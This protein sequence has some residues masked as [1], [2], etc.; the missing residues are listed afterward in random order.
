MATFTAAAIQSAFHNIAVDL[1]VSIQGASYQTSLVICVLGGAPIFWRPLSGRFGRR[2]I[3]LLSLI[4]SLIGNIGCAKAPTYGTMGLCRA[5]TA[6]FISPAAAIGSAVVQETF[7][8]NQRARYMGVWTMFVTL[9]VPVAPFI[10][11]FVAQRVSYRWIYW[12]LAMV[13]SL[14]FSLSNISMTI[15]NKLKQINGVQFI[16]YFFFGPES[17]YVR[18]SAAA[19]EKVI[20]GSK[21][22]F[23][24]IDKSPLTISDFI[25]PFAL[26]ARPVIIIPAVAYSMVFG[27]S[28]VMPTV[29]LPQ[30]YVEYFGLETQ[31]VG[32]QFVAVIIGTIVGEQLSGFISDRWMRRGH[33]HKAEYRLWLSYPGFALVITGIIVFLVTLGNAGE[34]YTVAP[35]VGAGIAAAG[36]QLITTVMIT[37]AVDCYREEAAAI[38]VLITFIRQTWGF[39][40]PFWFPVA[41]AKT[42]FGA[43]AGIAVALVVGVSIAPTVLLQLKGRSW[44]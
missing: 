1:G 20:A 30:L 11:G 28:N 42:G 5:I 33:D 41:I 44:H 6:F 24:R 34:T 37:Y 23:G 9:G 2:P 10:F 35:T 14:F 8:K 22:R 29:E 16:L 40:V 13:C 39:I 25:H 32:I 36:N 26:A 21:F 27:L 17:R 43:S 38:G 15:T 31:D 19:G 18:G 3:F 12:I 7:F 4:C